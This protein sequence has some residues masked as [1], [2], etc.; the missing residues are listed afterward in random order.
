MQQG[1][2]WHGNTFWLSSQRAMYWEEAQTL[3]ASDLHLGK[4]GH[5]RKSGIAVP[6]EVMKQDLMRLFDLL[7]HYS[8]KR[9]LVVGD[10]F[11]SHANKELDW[12]LR[13]RNDMPQLEFLL[14]KGNHDILNQAWYEAAGIDTVEHW[15]H[16]GID[17]S[18]EPAQALAA[19]PGL[20][21]VCGHIHPGIAISGPG[22]QH[23]RMP[24]FFFGKTQCILPAFGLF[25][26]THVVKPKRTDVVFA[27]ADNQIIRL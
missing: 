21:V 26:G 7:Q 19:A 13:W 23:L 5:F 22:R 11:H 18:H 14:V 25:T 8:P 1:F 16:H 24:C 20:P 15:N 12:F 6:Q 9:L 3:V 17:F 27:I 2:S 10:L 4:S